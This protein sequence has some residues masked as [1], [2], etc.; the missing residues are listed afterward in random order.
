ML[1]PVKRESILSYIDWLIYLQTSGPGVDALDSTRVAI[2]FQHHEIHEGNHY[3]VSVVDLD[4]DIAG[5]KYV[6]ITAPDSATRIH[7]VGVAS[8]DGA[9]LVEFYEDP[10]I[11]AA[12]TALTEYNNDRNSANTATATTFED[13]TTQAPN[14]DGTLLFAGRIGGTGRAQTRIAGEL[15]NR[16][17]WILEQNEDYLVKVTVDANNTEVII[18][19]TW[20]E[21]S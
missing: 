4:V 15:A 8:A 9:A 1:E 3:T 7:F 16:E 5:P 18:V 11:L 10:T 19:L 20:Y 13:T 2:A 14:N 12:G 6:R 21:V 17:E